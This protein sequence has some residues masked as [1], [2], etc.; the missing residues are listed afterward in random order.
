MKEKILIN[1][2]NKN[3]RLMLVIMDKNERK[4]MAKVID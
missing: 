3:T 1:E 2:Q 4:I